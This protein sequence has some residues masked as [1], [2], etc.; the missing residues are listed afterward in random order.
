MV[1]F[2]QF[3]Q[4]YPTKVVPKGQI[5]LHQGDEPG[6][7]YVIKSGYVKMYEITSA[8]EE[9]PLLFDHEYETFPIAWVFSH[10]DVANY[11]YE[12]L[13]ECELYL[14]PRSDYIAF[15][16]N[17]A[18]S[19]FSLFS[20]F[21]ERYNDFQMR[22]LALEQLKASDKVFYTLR[23]LAARFGKASSTNNDEW[24]ISI[25][26]TQQDIANFVGLTRE[27]TGLELK[28]L[29]REG[30]IRYSNQEYYIKRTKFDA[31]LDSK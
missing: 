31:L 29:E 19:Q 2:K 1:K 4:N 5:I 7:A 26:L 17:N 21:V 13:T 6:C 24:E 15:L 16:Q 10:I 18:M 28:R 22:I 27:T 12:A 25:P 8:G 20:H 14:V 30:V 11:Y 9:K 3:L 23:F